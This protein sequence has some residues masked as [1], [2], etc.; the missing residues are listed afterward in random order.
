[1]SRSATICLMYMII[2][3]KYKFSEA[4][5]LMK[6]KRK[7]VMPNINFRKLLEQ[8]SYEIHKEM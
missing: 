5:P 1:M 7:C 2:E 8:K 6:Q 4:Y 3:K